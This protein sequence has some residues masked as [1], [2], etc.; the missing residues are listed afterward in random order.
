LGVLADREN[1][2]YRS[3]GLDT[4]RETVDLLDSPYILKTALSGYGNYETGQKIFKFTVYN[5][6][7]TIRSLDELQEFKSCLT[8]KNIV[9]SGMIYMALKLYLRD[10]SVGRKQIEEIC[11]AYDVNYKWSLRDFLNVEILK[12]LYPV[13]MQNSDK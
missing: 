1:I 6:L 11:K 2:Y 12:E 10:G 9:R 5:R 3:N 7:E 8:T 13:E 4:I